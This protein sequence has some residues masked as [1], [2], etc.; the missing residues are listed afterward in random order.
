MTIDP[1]SLLFGAVAA[2]LGTGALISWA[3][4]RKRR[5][6]YTEYS[7]IRGFQ[8]EPRH[9]EGE[10]RFRDVF[11]PFQ[12][13]NS[14]SWRNTITGTKNQTPFIAFEY[15]W[16]TGASKYQNRHHV[17]GIIWER[18]DVSFPKFAL[19]P[20]GWLS[21]AGHIFGMQDIDF[22]DSPEF[23]SAYR[24]TGPN[25]S[26]IKELFT[27]EIR[28]FFAATPN[29]RV[30]GGGRFLIWWFEFELPSVTRLDEWLEGGDQVRRRFFKQ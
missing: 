25:E 3:R 30:T 16:T 14:D 17:S 2:V 28:Q 23:S 19:V 9:P 21:R 20:Q 15:V 5:E 22:A 18:D 4:Q 1:Q 24:L 11:E 13:G 8:Y 10:R 12:K 7:L 27:P 6:A 29:Q 26:A